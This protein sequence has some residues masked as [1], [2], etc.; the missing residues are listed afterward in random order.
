ME[1]KVGDLVKTNEKALINIKWVL[2]RHVT[3]DLSIG[4]RVWACWVDSTLT[5][6]HSSKCIKVKL[7]ELWN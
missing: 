2:V 4:Y 7:S 3:H 5:W 6:L 1:I